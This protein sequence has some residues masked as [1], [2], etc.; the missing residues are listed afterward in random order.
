MGS[1]DQ[2]KR[3]LRWRRF[4]AIAFQLCFWIHR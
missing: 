4:I 3:F 2:L 1:C